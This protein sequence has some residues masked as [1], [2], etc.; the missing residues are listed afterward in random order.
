[1]PNTKQ[2]N[3]DNWHDT[4]ARITSKEFSPSDEI[5]ILDFGGGDGDGYHEINKR[6]APL[7][8]NLNWNILE[9]PFF[10]DKYK[11]QENKNLKWH[12]KICDVEQKID[13][14]YSDA[15]IQCVLKWKEK[16][17]ELCSTNPK[18]VFINRIPLVNHDTFKARVF[19]RPEYMYG[20][21]GNDDEFQVWF[22]NEEEFIGHMDCLGYS[23]IQKT[24]HSIHNQY[25]P[26]VLDSNPDEP[27]ERKSLV[28][29]KRDKHA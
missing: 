9:L 3:T 11:K 22:I 14:L 20:I 6:L 26:L 13:I 8:Y 4:I 12:S 5:K 19:R 10:V 27:K 23:L 29:K 17:D 25:E 1:M 18:Y 15:S 28:F 24:F 21:S 16:M 7:G 2:I